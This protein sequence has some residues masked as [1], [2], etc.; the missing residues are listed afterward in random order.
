MLYEEFLQPVRDSVDGDTQVAEQA[1]RATL[2][3]ED[4][5]DLLREP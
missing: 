2:L 4:Y 5:R 1:V 3:T